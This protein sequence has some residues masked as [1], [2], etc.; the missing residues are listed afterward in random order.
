VAPPKVAKVLWFLVS[1]FLQQINWC[2]VALPKVAIVLG[3][4]MA[5]LLE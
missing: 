2:H 3:F 1:N 5:I 4:I